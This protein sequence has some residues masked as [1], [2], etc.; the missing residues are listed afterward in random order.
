[1][2]RWLPDMLIAEMR[3][4]TLLAIKGCTIDINQGHE[5]ETEYKGNGQNTTDL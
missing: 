1:M 5:E 2:N 4:S 3:Y